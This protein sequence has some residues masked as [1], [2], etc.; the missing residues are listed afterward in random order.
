MAP[1]TGVER[2]SVVL[3]VA[4]RVRTQLRFVAAS[5]DV[6]GRDMLIRMTMRNDTSGV[7]IVA[8]STMLGGMPRPVSSPSLVAAGATATVLVPL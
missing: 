4:P 2:R 3:N 6:A 8:A 7:V 5:A 1:G